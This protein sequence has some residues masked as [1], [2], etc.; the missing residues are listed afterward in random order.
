LPETH[1]ELW[2]A[3]SAVKAGSW[4]KKMREDLKYVFNKHVLPVLGQYSPRKITLTPLQLLVNKM[5]E[6]GYSKSAVKHVRTY[7]KACFEDAID[8]DLTP[9][10]PARKLA[11]PNIQK[12]S[13]ERFLSV[14]EVQAL[15]SAASQREHLVLRLLALVGCVPARLSLCALTI[16]KAHN[17]ESMKPSRSVSEAMIALGLQRRTR[18]TAMFRFRPTSA[19]RLQNGLRLIRIAATLALSSS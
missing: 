18:A 13:C 5:A 15:L 11:M 3:Y 4:G 19:A 14:E 9:K 12:K 17:S 6:D 8:E 7:L 2:N 1:A 16:L 10:N